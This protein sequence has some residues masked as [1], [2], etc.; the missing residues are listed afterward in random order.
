MKKVL[1]TLAI[2]LFAAGSAN[3]MPF[4]LDPGAVLGGGQGQTGVFNQLGTYLQTTSTESAGLFSDVG[5]VA[6]TSLIPSVTDNGLDQTWFLYGGWSD[7]VGA[8]PVPGTFVYTSGTLDLYVSTT[9]YDFGTSI[10]AGDDTGFNS[11]TKVATLNLVEGYG[12]LTQL[13]NGKLIGTVD[14][15]WEFTYLNSS[16]WLDQNGTPIDLSKLSAGEKL[17]AFADANTDLV[18]VNNLGGGVTQILSDHNGSVSIGVVPE[19]ASMALFGTG[20]FGLAGA[21]LRK[22]ILG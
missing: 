15:T 13:P 14:L 19:P 10:G 6:V 21:G 8:Q 3:A 16:F 7:L 22:K 11:G 17:F 18:E 2:V 4:M 20:L 9:K 12:F 1:V 5:N